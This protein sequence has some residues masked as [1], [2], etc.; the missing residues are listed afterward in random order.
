MIAARSR[1]GADTVTAI[2]GEWPANELE[3]VSVC[4][5]C[6]SH[7][8]KILH[9]GL[10]DLQFQCAPGA[11]T[12]HRCLNCSSAYLDPRPTPESI[13]RAYS[14]YYTHGS[15][16]TAL[17]LWGKL[18]RRVRYGFL[19]DAHG[20]D[21][22]PAWRAAAWLTRLLP[23]ERSVALKEIRHLTKRRDGMRVLD[24]GCGSGAFL[25]FMRWQGWSVHGL[26]PDQAAVDTARERGLDVDGARSKLTRAARRN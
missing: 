26:E 9:S 25:D 12:F 3:A 7:E 11:W 19:N 22:S 13:G 16:G 20:Y 6:G 1:R 23:R 2:G 14:S 24:V 10:S 8:R 5:V 15:V 4:P 21:L 17:G 18:Q